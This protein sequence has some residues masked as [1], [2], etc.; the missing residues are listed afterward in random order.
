MFETREYAPNDRSYGAWLLG[1]IAAALL[2]LTV[3]ACNTVSGM[4]ED[5]EAAGGAVSDTAEDVEDEI[6]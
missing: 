2:A 3:S 5:V 1:L 6:D 4:G